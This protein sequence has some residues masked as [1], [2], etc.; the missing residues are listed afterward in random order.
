[1]SNIIRLVVPSDRT[2]GHCPTCLRCSGVLNIG[3][4]QWGY[5]TTH[6]VKWRIG[7]NIFKTWLGETEDD[8]AENAQFLAWFA[9]AVYWQAPDPDECPPADGGSAA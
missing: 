3:G 4:M 9:D 1:M 5:C 6:G 8:W 2:V 7:Y